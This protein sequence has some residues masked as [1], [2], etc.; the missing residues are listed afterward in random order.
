MG[1]MS[2]QTGPDVS[3]AHVTPLS[4]DKNTLAGSNDSGD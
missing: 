2:I 4:L 1:R 3:V